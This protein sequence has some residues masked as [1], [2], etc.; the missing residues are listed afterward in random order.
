[1]KYVRYST[2]PVFWVLTQASHNGSHEF[3]NSI[4][5]F[6]LPS[7]D[8]L[9]SFIFFCFPTSKTLIPLLL[10]YNPHQPNFFELDSPT[11]NFDEDF[12]PEEK[13]QAILA[14]MHAKTGIHGTFN[15]GAKG[16]I[17]DYKQAKDLKRQQLELEQQQIR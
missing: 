14:E 1:M 13:K 17:N 7:R 10:N 6:R 4:L 9:S 5:N 2:N 16:V 8:Q 12:V 3:K 15:T 11:K